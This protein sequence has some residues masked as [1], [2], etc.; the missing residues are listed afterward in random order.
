MAVLAGFDTPDVPLESFRMDPET[1]E[2]SYG[3][4]RGSML[5]ITFDFDAEDFERTA[6]LPGSALAYVTYLPEV[7]TGELEDLSGMYMLA[8]GRIDVD[9]IDAR[10][11]AD[12]EFA[13][14]FE[15]T[16]VSMDRSERIR[17]ADG[18]FEVK[19]AVYWESESEES[20]P[21]TPRSE[22]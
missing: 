15:G 13:G 16:L 8:E 20:E 4:Y 14:S 6:R 11:G 2:Y 9:L 21:E 7:G 22:R 5:G 1:G 12:S 17:V 3:S 18:R 10:R 19:G